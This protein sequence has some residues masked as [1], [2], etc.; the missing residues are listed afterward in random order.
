M[1]LASKPGICAGFRRNRRQWLNSSFVMRFANR[2][3]LPEDNRQEKIHEFITDHLIRNHHS[4]GRC[5]GQEPCEEIA[6]LLSTGAGEPVLRAIVSGPLDAD[7]QDYLL[8]DSLFA[9]TAHIRNC[10]R[11]SR[12]AISVCEFR[13]SGQ[14]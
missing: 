9:G 6:K 8:R 12:R 13:L 1:S 10:R 4:V 11:I 14:R 5:L 7:K 2:E 3:A